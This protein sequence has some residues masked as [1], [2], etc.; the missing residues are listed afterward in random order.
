[1]NVRI[2][3]PYSI[4]KNLGKA[5][6]EEMAL[7]PDGDAACFLDGDMMFTIPDYGHV[8]NEYANLYPNAVLTCWTNRTHNLSVG[9]QHPT[10]RASNVEE[11]L[12]FASTIS[13]DRT[14]ARLDGV[15]SML[16]QVIPKHIWQQYKFSEVNMYRPDEHNL[17]GVDNEWTNRIR[18]NG[19][20]ILRMNGLI[21]YHQYRLLTGS[22]EHLK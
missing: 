8:I 7:I 21:M 16:L 1:M 5:Y 12:R 18:S 10:C 17:L 6:N 11:V 19:I 20:E 3:T 15:V 22:K 9:Q 13:N 4:D 2:R 14:V